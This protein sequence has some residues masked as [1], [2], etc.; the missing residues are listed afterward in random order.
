MSPSYGIE[1]LTISFLFFK[2][3]AASE[4]L[5][6]VI[7]QPIAKH[8]PCP[9]QVQPTAKYKP[10]KGGVEGKGKGG[11]EGGGNG[12]LEGKG[13]SKSAYFWHRFWEAKGVEGKG[14]GKSKSGVMEQEEN[15]EDATGA[16]KVTDFPKTHCV[17]PKH[18]ILC[19]GA[20][21]PCKIDFAGSFEKR[22]EI[23]HPTK[24]ACIPGF[25]AYYFGGE[26]A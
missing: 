20:H 24:R 8:K 23:L 18:N 10:R 22:L 15:E 5:A 13:K 25:P 21:P 11:V 19:V 17:N 1:R 4:E 9:K 7:I 6:M 14:K 26:P 16:E 3:A 2:L 12:G